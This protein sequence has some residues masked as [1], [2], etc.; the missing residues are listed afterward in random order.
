MDPGQ[1]ER[2]RR[3]RFPL[4]LEAVVRDG[5]TEIRGQTVNV[6]SGGALV[7][8]TTATE[9]AAGERIEVRLVWPVSHDSCELQLCFMGTVAWSR[10]GL[11]AIRAERNEFRTLPR[12]R[13][14]GSTSPPPEHRH[15]TART[16]V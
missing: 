14:P 12:K 15:P 8:L 5:K 13:P 4:W 9:F 11:V 7:S 16:K 3:Q 2:R 6:G 1:K 10:A